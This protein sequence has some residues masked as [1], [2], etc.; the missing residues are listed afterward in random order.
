MV[1]SRIPECV[2]ALQIDLVP[3]ST[4]SATAILGTTYGEKIQV[5]TF[6]CYIRYFLVFPCW[7]L[8]FWK[9]EVPGQPI[10][11][12]K[13]DTTTSKVFVYGDFLV[14]IFRHSD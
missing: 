13:I 7:T 1:P 9:P 10:R 12:H 6:Y 3:T 5:V 11:F 14:H 8:K 4:G 2:H